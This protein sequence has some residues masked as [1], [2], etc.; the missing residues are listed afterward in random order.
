MRPLEEYEKL[1]GYSF[2][3]RKLLETALTHSSYAPHLRCRPRQMNKT[4]LLQA[5][6]KLPL[7]Q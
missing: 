2:R 6:P 7:R 3:D 4:T 1:I 5:L